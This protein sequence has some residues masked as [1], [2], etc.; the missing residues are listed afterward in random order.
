MPSVT[1]NAYEVTIRKKRSKDLEV[2][3]DF[4]N[5]KDIIDVLYQTLT[6]WCYEGNN[7]NVVEDSATSKRLRINKESLNPAGRKIEGIIETGE[8][9]YESNVVDGSGKQTK[10]I[11]KNESP[12]L[13]FYFVG[14]FPKDKV[15][16]I[17][18]FQKFKNFGVYG[19]FSKNIKF[20]FRSQN[21]DYVISILPLVSRELI[22]RFF[23]KG[24]LRQISFKNFLN[25]KTIVT[26]SDRE[27]SLN[28]ENYYTEYNIIAK[29]RK[30]LGIIKR[31]K[32]YVSGNDNLND[33]VPIHNFEYNEIMVTLQ[34][35]NH[36][37]TIKL[38]GLDNIGA[39]FDI[40]DEVTID[41][42]TG[43]PEFD[44]VAE[45]SKKVLDDV[46]NITGLL[47]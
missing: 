15:T 34:L 1:L 38:S 5:G 40:T 7:P 35:E 47:Q 31:L 20:D 19:V 10:K 11:N 13:P 24:A 9:G 28:E 27:I 46:L 12:M 3:S 2:L 44:S 45:A 14:Y 29:R 33:L 25:N 18:I 26:P 39:F 37:R 16:G 4:N 32:A 42:N 22:D 23:D 17:I 8:Y 6:R 36:K 43:L 21:E 41:V 30:K